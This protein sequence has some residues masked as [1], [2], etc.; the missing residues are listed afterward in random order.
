MR[1]LIETTK[2]VLFIDD[3]HKVQKA[4]INCQREVDNYLE[5]RVYGDILNTPK[6]IETHELLGIIGG[7]FYTSEV[8]LNSSNAH[9]VY[10]AVGEDIDIFACDLEID[11]DRV[12]SSILLK[13]LYDV[14]AGTFKEYFHTD[15]LPVITVFMKND[16]FEHY[17]LLEHPVNA[18][19]VDKYN[20][21]V[22]SNK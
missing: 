9:C 15:F 20:I 1:L 11:L 19:I 21:V 7:T 10:D 6:S 8:K 22:F 17:K 3:A 13:N 16:V 14:I 2:D 18:K 5:M 4:D 12:N